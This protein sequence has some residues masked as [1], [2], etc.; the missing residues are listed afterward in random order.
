MHTSKLTQVFILNRIMDSQS[1]DAQ[2]IEGTADSEYSIE[3]S[4]APQRPR[5]THSTTSTRGTQRHEQRSRSKDIQELRKLGA[6]EFTGTTDLAEA[7]AWLK[8]TERIFAVMGSTEEDQLILIVS[9]LQGDAFD[10]WE[11]VPNATV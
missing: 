4:Q 6:K 1:H 7:E 10:W 9:L 8:S 11:T 3:V 2:Q 5:R